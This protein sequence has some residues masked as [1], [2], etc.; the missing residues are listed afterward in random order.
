[1]SVV[2]AILVLAVS[3]LALLVGIAGFLLA[4]HSTTDM[5]W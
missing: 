4:L 3:A 1:M 2:I 5:R